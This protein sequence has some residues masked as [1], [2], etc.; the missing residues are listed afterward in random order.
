MSMA[1]LTQRLFIVSDEDA[2]FRMP[3]AMFKR[4][5]A[6]PAEYHLPQFANQRLRFACITVD[7]KDRKPDSVIRIDYH[8]IHFTAD[9]AIDH[10]RFMR[11]GA[12]IMDAFDGMEDFSSK[13]DGNIIDGTKR[14][15]RRE[16]DNAILWQPSVPLEKKIL[17]ASIDLITLPRI[18]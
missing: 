18:K 9:G 12:V 8:Y 4:L 7:L 13:S 3:Q 2:V 5:M 17:D 1:A 15:A 6:N 14:F 16:R 11:D 10:Q